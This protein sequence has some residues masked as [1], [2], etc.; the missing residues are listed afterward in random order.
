M[1][2]LG[3]SALDNDATACLYDDGEWTAIG[4][5][6]L[7]R[8]KMHAG[9]PKLAIQ[10]LLREKGFTAKDVDAVCYPFMPWWVEG[11]RMVFGY[12]RDL[13]YTLFNGDG[14]G[15]KFRHLKAYAVWCA[16]AI[17]YHKTYHQKLIQGLRDDGFEGKLVRIDHH[18]S[19][20]AAAFL[21]SGFDEAVALTLDWY[22]G[23][24]AGSVSRCRN[25]KI[26]RLHDY[27]YPHSTGLFYAQVTKA[28]GF[29]ASRHEGKIV[30]LAAYGDVKELGERV[31]ARFDIKNGNYKYKSGMDK[32]F[33]E[34]LAKDYSRE[35][36]AAAW[37]YALE[38]VIAR[39]AAYWVQRTGIPNVVMAGGVA[40]NV[41]MNQRV[42]E[43]PG[44]EQ[45]FIHPAMGDGGTSVGA[46][47]AHLYDRGAITSQEWKTCYLGP[48]YTEEQMREALEAKGL[49]PIR[50]ENVARDV[51]E[52]LAQGKVVARFGGRMEYGPRALGNR[53]ILYPATEPEVNKW[54][55]DRLGRTEF[56]PFAPV[57]LAEHAKER[58]VH[59]ERMRIPARFMTITCDCTELMKQESPAAVHVDGTARPQLVTPEENPAY[60]AILKEYHA[61][62]GIPTLINTSFN[63]HEEPI[64]CTP[65]DAVRAF[66]LGHLDYLSMGP[67]LVPFEERAGEK[68][69]S[70]ERAVASHG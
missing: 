8:V 2:I 32:T 61:L 69:W 34:Q 21:T 37:Q 40:A 4:E 62:T 49:E 39:V 53:S 11:R 55:N 28:L 23:G 41:K 30:G 12:L 68:E 33:V 3:I 43:A 47:V 7:S 65:Q 57:S 50:S 20:A 27:R 25:G 35:H 56:M 1:R 29:K 59:I 36:V 42:M 9:Y 52:L 17:H 16:R 54:L 51:A 67:Y 60:Y 48:E 22:G 18:T 15:R 58:Y 38:Q 5:E 45:V 24:L 6:R 63:M 44:V 66:L 14:L 31:L 10:E 19:H 26:E 13:P 46:V 64:V 70:Q